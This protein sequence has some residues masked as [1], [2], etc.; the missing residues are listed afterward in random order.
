MT[1]LINQITLRLALLTGVASLIAS[2]AW[3]GDPVA[4]KEKAA[5]CAAC[6]G[7]DGKTPIDPSYAILAGQHEDYLVV[8]LKAYRSGNRKNAIM[9]AQSQA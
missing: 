8:A 9:G 2:P 4:G 6:H 5:V 7:A 3:A 1:V